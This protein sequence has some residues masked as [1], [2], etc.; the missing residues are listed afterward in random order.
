MLILDHSANRFNEHKLI[1]LTDRIDRGSA[2]Y[3]GGGRFGDVY[4]CRYTEPS[5]SS[6]S[7]VAVKSLRYFVFSGEES[8]AINKDLRRELGLWR[9][10]DFDHQNI[11][12]LLGV[13]KWHGPLDAI[14]SAWMPNGTLHSFLKDA[15][16]THTLV[17][18]FSILRGIASCLEY[19]H[20]ILVL[21]GDLT[22]CNI[23]IDEECKPRI[24][25]FGLSS[26]LGKLQPGMTY[27]NRCSTD[28]GA[29]RWAAPELFDDECKPK[30]S[31]DVYSFGCIMLEVLSGKIPWE[32]RPE[33][34][35]I[36]LKIV[37]RKFPDRPAA[38][39]I[40][41]KHWE[42]MTK[43]WLLPE[44]RPSA[45]QVVRYLTDL[46]P[47]DPR[48]DCRV[49]ESIRYNTGYTSTGRRKALL[50]AIRHITRKSDIGH[51]PNI[52]CAHRDARALRD[53]LIDS[54][55]YHSDDVVLM[56]DDKNLPKELW[57]SRKRI[58]RKI[59]QLVDNASD[60]THFFFYFSGRCRESQEGIIA[61]D[62]KTISSQVVCKCVYSYTLSIPQIFCALR[63]LSLR[64]ATGPTD[65]PGSKCLFKKVA[66]W[67]WTLLQ[68]RR[69]INRSTPTTEQEALP[70]GRP[71][72][73]PTARCVTP[74]AYL[75][76]QYSTTSYTDLTK[77][78]EL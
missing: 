16:K 4:K 50:I 51:H 18:R 35:V 56:M 1:D 75:K 5:N 78:V 24:T 72:I 74:F 59:D 33:R 6:P 66:C 28:P 23:L 34:V 9:R 31:V 19:L 38:A 71:P 36:G 37:Q 13:T 58:L 42:F 70:T 14:V 12:P 57:A 7:T 69:Y 20:S 46:E 22:S 10:L 30:P 77:P 49:Q 67:P 32:G 25:D 55:G 61:G 47:G 39:Q 63:L 27:L 76:T 45:Q 68:S 21:H 11:V 53:H 2:I 60:T 54:H 52:H 8:E 65:R 64:K 73:S 41:D 29:I 44:K 62:G 15:G 43:C 40:D 26:A 3:C 17:Q 48:G